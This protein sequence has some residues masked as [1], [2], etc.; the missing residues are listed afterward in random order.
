MDI[1]GGEGKHPAPNRERK[2]A[3]ARREG[4]DKI[5]RYHSRKRIDD[6]ANDVAEKTASF[7]SPGSQTPD[8]ES[9]DVDVR[10]ACVIVDG[11]VIVHV[12]EV[13]GEVIVYAV[14]VDCVILAVTYR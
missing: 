9:H 11:E 4:A 8:V 13:D 14:E 5:E 10:S 1:C 7:V 6:V 3:A 2:A 12:I